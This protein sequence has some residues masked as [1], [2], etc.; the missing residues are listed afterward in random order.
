[1]TDDVGSVFGAEYGRA[2]SVLTGVL[3]DPDLAEDAVQAAFEIAIWKWPRTGTPASPAGWIITTA[4]RQAIDRIRREEK[5]DAKELAALLLLEQGR[6]EPDARA[7]APC[8]TSGCGCSS[9]AA[10]PL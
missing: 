5:R 10:I 9:R 4:R 8:R 1:M 6:P 3:G 7:T 2:V